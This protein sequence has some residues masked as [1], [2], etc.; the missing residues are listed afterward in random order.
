MNDMD[1]TW[2]LVCMLISQ[3][4][5]RGRIQH[6]LFTGRHSSQRE[7]PSP[8]LRQFQKGES[9]AT[10]PVS[11]A[12]V[13]LPGSHSLGKPVREVGAILRN[14]NETVILYGVL[15]VTEH[16]QAA[17]SIPT[18]VPISHNIDKQRNGSILVR[19]GLIF[20]PTNW[21][22]SNMP[23]TSY[24]LTKL[25]LFDELITFGFLP[26]MPDWMEESMSII[27][28]LSL[29]DL[30][31]PGTYQSAA[32]RRYRVNDMFRPRVGFIYTQ[33]ED[34]FTQLLYGIRYLDLRPA[35]QRNAASKYGYDYWI[36][37]GRMPTGHELA[38]ILEDVANFLNIFP[39][40]VVFIDISPVVYTDEECA[41]LIQ[42]VAEK[43]GNVFTLT[44][45]ERMDFAC[46]F[47]GGSECPPLVW[48][49][50]TLDTLPK[51]SFSE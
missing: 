44:K 33:E 50:S 10:E 3:V 26:L 19:T 21:S 15:L 31:I 29:S 39:A 12:I 43:L 1:T 48:Y 23:K 38:P 13:L 17:D 32:Y 11:I 7:K 47:E 2:V 27:G 16:T 22:R 46:Y 30:V 45:I 42:L 51:S 8:L 37:N 4:P 20:A 24:L 49:L 6:D 28:F 41:G 9:V 35:A 18:S 5:T 25:L 34:I 14:V 40:E 36:L